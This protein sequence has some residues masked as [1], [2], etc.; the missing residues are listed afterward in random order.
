MLQR[1]E[2]PGPSLPPIQIGNER[3]FPGGRAAWLDAGHILRLVPILRIN[4]VKPPLAHKPSRLA[5][6][7]IYLII[8]VQKYRS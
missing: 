8:S 6:E 4:G 2:V 3:F 5:Q 1:R 7:Q